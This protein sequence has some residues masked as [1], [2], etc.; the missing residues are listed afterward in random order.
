MP[1]KQM[2][3]LG[4]KLPNW[5]RQFMSFVVIGFI[6]TFLDAAILYTLSL[7]S[8]WEKG[9]Q[10]GMLQATSFI[11]VATFSFFANKKWTFREKGGKVKQEVVD[12]FQFISI[13]LG[14]LIIKVGIVTSVTKFI[15]PIHLDILF[16]DFQ[17]TPRLWLVAAS[18]GATAISLIWNFLG[19][20]FVVFKK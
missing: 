13:T 19:Y 3:F 6:N 18:L 9:I 1:E 16:I 20:K 10:A 2:S 4:F 5:M 15:E 8:G 7:L 14:G 12:Y 17:F 11:I